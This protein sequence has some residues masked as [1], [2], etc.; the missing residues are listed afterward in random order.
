M[1]EMDLKRMKFEI[2][3]EEDKH[4]MQEEKEQKLEMMRWRE[5]LKEE[6]HKVFLKKKIM[7][8]KI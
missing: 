1:K 6:H 5:L 8:Q 4:K 3:S 2:I 7:E